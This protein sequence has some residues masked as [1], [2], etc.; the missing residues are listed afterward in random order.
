MCGCILATR[1]YIIKFVRTTLYLVIVLKFRN[2]VCF[3]HFKFND[4][5][6]KTSLQ[7][8]YIKVAC[9]ITLPYQSE[10]QLYNKS[11]KSRQGMSSKKQKIELQLRIIRV[12]SVLKQITEISRDKASEN[13]HRPIG[14][15]SLS[16]PK[17]IALIFRLE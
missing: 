3:L 6:G 17:I 14:T 2:N 5:V 8:N 15:V 12:F 7:G 10:N 16:A 9:K 13:Q 1:L 11:S 4:V